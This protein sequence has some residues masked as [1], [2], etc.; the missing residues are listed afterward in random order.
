MVWLRT[1]GWVYL[2]L[3]AASLCLSFLAASVLHFTG[4]DLVHILFPLFGHAIGTWSSALTG[5]HAFLLSAT[6][7]C[8]TT[9]ALAFLGLALL[10]KVLGPW[11]GV[12]YSRVW[13]AN[14][15]Q[16]FYFDILLRLNHRFVMTAIKIG[17][18]RYERKDLQINGMIC[19]DKINS[20][21]DG[22]NLGDTG[23]VTIF[24][25][26]ITID[27]SPSTTYGE[28]KAALRDYGFKKDDYPLYNYVLD[29]GG[30]APPRG[31]REWDSELLS[32]FMLEDNNK[33]VEYKRFFFKG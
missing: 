22:A 30:D 13:P 4:H 21:I 27:I 14:K 9:T 18:T 29:N 31:R 10:R 20:L 17:D 16:A 5:L 32:F 28:V 15:I 8:L 7:I 24:F 3:P 23:Q 1:P 33:P 26:L 11:P 2:L 6:V 25:K 12:E 19:M